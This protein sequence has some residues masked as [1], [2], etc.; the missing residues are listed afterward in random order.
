MRTF[1]LM[2]GKSSV[3]NS[4]F[5][6]GSFLVMLLTREVVQANLGLKSIARLTA[7]SPVGVCRLPAL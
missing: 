2:Y 5:L 4:L 7:D 6:A 3:V 1:S